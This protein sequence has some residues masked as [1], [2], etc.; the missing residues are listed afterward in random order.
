MIEIITLASYSI[1][2]IVFMSELSK[3]LNL[4]YKDTTSGF[5]ENDLKRYK[6]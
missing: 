3:W 5:D 6:G 2:A 4:Q 1:K